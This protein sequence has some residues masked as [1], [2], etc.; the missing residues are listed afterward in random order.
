MFLDTLLFKRTIVIGIYTVTFGWAISFAVNCKKVIFALG[1]DLLVDP[2]KNFWKKITVKMAL[3]RCNLLFVDN[4]QGIKNAYSLGFNGVTKFSPYGVEIPTLKSSLDE[5]IRMYNETILWV[6][7]TNPIYNIDCLLMALKELK[8]YNKT[9]W[10]V[11][12]AGH[13]TSSRSFK[14]K[15]KKYNLEKHAQL[16]GFIR[17][18]SEMADL[19]SKASIFVSSSLSDGTS[20]ALLE[21]MAYGLT[22]VV[23]DF[24]NN[25]LWIKNQRNGFLFDPKKPEDLAALLDKILS[26]SISID[27]RKVMIAKSHKLVKKYGSLENFNKKVSEMLQLNCSS[28]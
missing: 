17:K 16:K 9:N 18:K 27:D 28:K 11:I 6:R 3:K 24:K 10:K 23:S 19:Y 8:K 5:R 2:Y 14:L 12:F 15:N 1:S 4:F 25:S 21:G 22:M 13:G 26:G 7:G 20:V